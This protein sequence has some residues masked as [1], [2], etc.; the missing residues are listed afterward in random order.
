LVLL[1]LKQGDRDHTVTRRKDKRRSKALGRILMASGAVAAIAGLVVGFQIAFEG[2][3]STGSVARAASV[4]LSGSPIGPQAASALGMTITAPG[5]AQALSSELANRAALAGWPGCS[6]GK[7]TYVHLLW[8]GRDP[9]TDADVFLVPLHCPYGMTA[10]RGVGPGGP[11]T[12]QVPA[13]TFKVAIVS[14]SGTLMETITGASSDP[15]PQ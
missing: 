1:E 12:S 6:I 13:A 3:A 2:P 15:S 11:S 4:P 14:A 7:T 10:A 9:A 8:A 5:R